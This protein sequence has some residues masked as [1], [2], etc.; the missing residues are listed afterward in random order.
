MPPRSRSLQVLVVVVASLL[1]A[2]V[3]SLLEVVVASVLPL[4][5]EVDSVALLVEEVDSRAEVVLVAS[6]DVVDQ[7]AVLLVAA[8]GEVTK[9]RASKN[10]TVGWRIMGLVYWR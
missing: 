6:V 2:V 5:E 1:E 9:R 7:E 10:V 3:A 4:A 8:D